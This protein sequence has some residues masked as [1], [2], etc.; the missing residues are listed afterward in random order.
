MCAQTFSALKVGLQDSASDM[1]E[2]VCTLSWRSLWNDA[3]KHQVP[4]HQVRSAIAV[5]GALS[6]RGAD[7]ER[8]TT[9]GCKR[10][11]HART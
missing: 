4:Y 7:R 1:F 10:R 11:L 9:T 2:Q 8:S 3:Q 6:D 5:R